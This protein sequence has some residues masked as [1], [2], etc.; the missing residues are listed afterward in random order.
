MTTQHLLFPPTGKWAPLEVVVADGTESAST[1]PCWTLLVTVTNAPALS[2]QAPPPARPHVAGSVPPPAATRYWWK[3]RSWMK[4]PS[5][6]GCRLPPGLHPPVGRSAGTPP[7]LPRAPRAGAATQTTFKDASWMV[8]N[9]T[10]RCM[11][12]TTAVSS[13]SHRKPGRHH[14]N[15]CSFASLRNVRMNF[16]LLAAKGSKIK[17]KINILSN[18]I[19]QKIYYGICRKHALSYPF[20]C[21]KKKY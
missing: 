13:A 14:L 17:L 10:P 8:E 21:K 20:K 18:L 3:K 16:G 9:P 15:R 7:W 4:A 12:S 5:T 6:L 11:A 1:S 2:A 19:G